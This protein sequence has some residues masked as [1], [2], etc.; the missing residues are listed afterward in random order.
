MRFLS[1]LLRML[2]WCSGYESSPQVCTSCSPVDNIA[3]KIA[4]D[5]SHYH[6]WWSNFSMDDMDWKHSSKDNRMYR[7]DCCL[8]IHIRQGQTHWFVELD[9]SD[10][11]GS[12]AAGENIFHCS[13]SVLMETSS[14]RLTETLKTK[15]NTIE[16]P[17]SFISHWLMRA[18]HN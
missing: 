18:T 7:C 8:K 13:Y 5:R 11:M 4:W 17:Q 9:N 10:S 12:C 1:T 14:A 16:K 2:P 15:G 3:A 6:R